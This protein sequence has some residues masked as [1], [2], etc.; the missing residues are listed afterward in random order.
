MKKG[1]SL[2]L[3]VNTEQSILIVLGKLVRLVKTCW[4]KN[5]ECLLFPVFLLSVKSTVCS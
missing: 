2:G 5:N 3:I 1:R 4:F